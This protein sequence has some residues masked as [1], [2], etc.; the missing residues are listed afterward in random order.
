VSSCLPVLNHDRPV[1]TC[2]CVHQ[3]EVSENGA[4]VHVYME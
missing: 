1:L 3:F 4:E 2:L